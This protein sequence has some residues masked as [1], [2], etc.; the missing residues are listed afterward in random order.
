MSGESSPSPSQLYDLIYQESR[1]DIALVSAQLEALQSKHAGNERRNL[2]VLELGV[3]T[4]RMV[5]G[6]LGRV[7]NIRYH[8]VDINSGFLDACRAGLRERAA[9]LAARGWE[10]RLVHH[11][12]TDINNAGLRPSSYDLAFWA[13][14]SIVYVSPERLASTLGAVAS[15]LS[16]KGRLLFDLTKSADAQDV[17][18]VGTQPR[19]S[20][21]K[22]CTPWGRLQV[23]HQDVVTADR[24]V[25][26]TFTFAIA[27]EGIEWTWA[28]EGY[29]HDSRDIEDAIISAGLRVHQRC[30]D[31]GRLT[32][33]VGA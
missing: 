5:W 33:L 30:Q 12:F 22:V 15:L 8:G 21:G 18:V 31:T 32:W 19:V 1:D 27:G 13:V 9:E 6:L 20:R 24:R 7:V 16:A 28:T 29:L 17:A 26:R 3:G 14:S 25:S 11:D 10:V 4:G 2:R 23:S